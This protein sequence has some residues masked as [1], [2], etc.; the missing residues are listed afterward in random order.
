MAEDVV[1]RAEFNNMKEDIKEIKADAKEQTKEQTQEMMGMRD[2]KIRT[3]IALEAIIKTQKDS[4][5][6]QIIM[7]QGIEDLKN[8]P[9]IAWSKMAMAWKITIGTV[10]IGS[11]LTYAFGSYMTFLKMFGKG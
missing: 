9:F 6:K 1:T 10:I 5:D 7:L 11:V 8:K 3:E 4:D 2:S